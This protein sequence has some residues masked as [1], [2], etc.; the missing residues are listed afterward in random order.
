MENY[1]HV[2]RGIR[3]MDT[4]YRTVCRTLVGLQRLR[5]GI[6]RTIA[7]DFTMCD[8]YSPAGKQR[9]ISV[10]ATTS[11]ASSRMRLRKTR[12]TA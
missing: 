3:D 11:N 4:V 10:N 7:D 6:D 12:R 5:N 2:A 9:L 1:V 8:R